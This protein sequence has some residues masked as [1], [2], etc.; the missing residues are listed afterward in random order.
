MDFDQAIAAHAAWKEK[1][2]DYLRKRDGSFKPAEIGMDTKCPLGQW[3][4]GEGSKYVEL[5]E[6]ST[7]RLE[8]ARFHKAAAEVVRRAHSGESA[9]ADIALGAKSESSNAAAAV[10]TAIMAMKHA[11]R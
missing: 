6:Y 5:P 7:L 1:L 8:D 10:V 3:I 2:R 11:P 9:S 4:H